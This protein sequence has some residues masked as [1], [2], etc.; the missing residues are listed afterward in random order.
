MLQMIEIRSDRLH[1]PR[2]ELQQTFVRLETSANESLLWETRVQAVV[3]ALVSSTCSSSISTAAQSE[4]LQRVNKRTPFDTLPLVMNIPPAAGA[5]KTVTILDIP[6]TMVFTNTAATAVALHRALVS[7]KL[8][9]CPGVDLSK[10]IRMLAGASHASAVDASAGSCSFAGMLSD[11]ATLRDATVS[12]SLQQSPIR[13]IVCTDALARGV[14]LPAVRH[15]VSAEF[16]ENVVTHL[17][18]ILI[19]VRV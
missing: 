9:Q 3:R 16:A 1:S 12:S 7:S 8:L 14:D 17:V 4:F 10:S 11:L 13:I 19:C 2:S 5:L 6:P 18:S 15:V